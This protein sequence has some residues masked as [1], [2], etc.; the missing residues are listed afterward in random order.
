MPT[1]NSKRTTSKIKYRELAPGDWPVVVSLFGRQGACGGCWCMWWRV[2]RGG[3]LWEETK[4]AK[5]RLQ[6]KRLIESGRMQAVLAFDGE[7]PVGWCTF[8][9]RKDF[10]RIETVKAYVPP[11]DASVW[12]IPCLFIIRAYRGQGIATELGRTAVAAA[13]RRGAVIV[14]GYPVTTTKDGRRVAP[15]YS[16]TGPLTVFEQCGFDIVQRINPLRPVV[17]RSVRCG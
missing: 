7:E 9:P 13:G 4:G 12:S 1:T 14:E 17:R 8:G 3:R 10:P 16:W 11:D 15:V 2:A 6:S 5:A